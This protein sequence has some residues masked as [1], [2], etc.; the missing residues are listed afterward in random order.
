MK[1]SKS[2]RMV[3]ASC[4]GLM[5]LV[6][7]S[8]ALYFHIRRPIVAEVDDSVLK[9][10]PIHIADDE[11][12]F[13]VCVA[14]VKELNASD[15]TF[16]RE[17]HRA[18]TLPYYQST[19]N[20]ISNH[21]CSVMSLPKI[22]RRFEVAVEGLREKKEFWPATRAVGDF[23][24]IARQCRDNALSVVEESV[25]NSLCSVAHV[26]AARLSAAEDA[27]EEVLDVLR[28]IVG[29]EADYSAIFDRVKKCEYTY[30]CKPSLLRIPGE[31]ECDKEALFAEVQR[32]LLPKV[33]WCA[34]AVGRLL[35]NTP[36]YR[37]FSF[38]KKALLQNVA[39]ILS[40]AKLDGGEWDLDTTKTG[41]LSP[42]WYGRLVVAECESARS[43]L[44]ETL[45]GNMMRDRFIRVIVALQ[46]YARKHGGQ[47]P[48]SIDA[49]VP[50][51]LD[52][53]PRDPYDVSSEIK[54][55]VAEKIVWSVGENRKYATPPCASSKKR[56]RDFSRWAM[57]IDGRPLAPLASG[58]LGDVRQN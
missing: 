25:A 49:L 4:A 37:Q 34:P 18:S 17:L 46:L 8:F 2:R 32:A 6:Y 52:A 10:D 1:Y 47:Y 31:G 56:M 36:G 15:E 9:V 57:R 19:T 45:V 3:L 30:W 14:M 27:P 48:V 33:G 21:L 58:T 54:Y 29:G 7:L 35:V 11:N 43:L 13:A 28:G 40:E 5:A 38:Q 41:I 24:V 39:S 16:L 42:N 26:Q 20:D 44:R 12:C 50:K 53:V 51:Y 23:Y 55:S 22:A